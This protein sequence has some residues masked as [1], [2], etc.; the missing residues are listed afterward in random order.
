MSRGS[1]AQSTQ[2][3]QRA[4][5]RLQRWEQKIQT[6]PRQEV[7][8]AAQQMY[9][10]MIAQTPYKT[11]ALERSVF[12]KVKGLTIQAGASAKSDQGY[13]YAGIQHENTEFNHPIKGKAFYI[14]DPYNHQV[15]LM[16]RR[17]R[18]K[19]RKPK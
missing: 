16:Q 17:I 7:Q 14:K 1:S 11:G 9:P 8:R 10:E 18:R 15:V 13:D 5:K 12:V 3:V 19:L 2:S 6:V 4:I